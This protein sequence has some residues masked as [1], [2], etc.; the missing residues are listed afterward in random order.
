MMATQVTTAQ[1]TFDGNYANLPAF[2]KFLEDWSHGIEYKRDTIKP[3]GSGIGAGG[4]YLWESCLPVQPQALTLQ[5]H[6]QWGNS[7]PTQDGSARHYDQ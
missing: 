2:D 7:Y 3:D 6:G 4:V 1:I 5:M